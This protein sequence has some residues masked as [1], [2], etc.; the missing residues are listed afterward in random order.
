MTIK[1]VTLAAVADV[2]AYHTQSIRRMIREGRFPKPIRMGGPGSALR[3]RQDEI[4][5]WLAAKVEA[6]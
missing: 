5:A 4:E 6:R 2:T 3:F 1:L